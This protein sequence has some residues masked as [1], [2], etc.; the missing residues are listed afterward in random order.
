MKMFGSSHVVVLSA[1]LLASV[2][3][4]CSSAEPNPTATSSAPTA[5]P[6]DFTTVASTT[7]EIS[8][9]GN[10]L[11]FDKVTLRTAVGQVVQLTLHNEAEAAALQHNW[12]LVKDG[13]TEA[14]GEAAL[15]AGP[16]NNYVP[17]N[18]TRVIAH[19]NLASGGQ[20]ESINFEA[21]AAGRYEFICSFPG[22]YT[23]MRGEF[24]VE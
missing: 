22:H 21:P 18:D 11:K 1:V 13:A 14:V 3:S 6:A 24:I 16:S 19:T 9:V 17:M 8:S 2:T 4:A 5:T 10:D 20:S 12:V 23:L 15:A 7:L